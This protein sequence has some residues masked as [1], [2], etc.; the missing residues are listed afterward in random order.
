LPP[1]GVA[2]QWG[3]SVGTFDGDMANFPGRYR[4]GEAIDLGVKNLST[5]A[6]ELVHAADDRNGNLNALGQHWR[7]E[8]VAE[9][10][11]SV[12]LEIL[13]RGQDADLGG[14]WQ[15]LQ[16]YA[17]QER[18]EVIEACMRVLERTCRAV[19]LILDTAEGMRRGG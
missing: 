14:C 12:L 17:R 7:S 10:G 16:H 18:I 9:L 15:Y 6:H 2:R 19:G 11:A 13:G 5:W 1:L 8:T 3:L 4:R